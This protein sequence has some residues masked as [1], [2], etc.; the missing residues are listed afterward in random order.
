[1]AEEAE[2]RERD[3]RP[4]RHWAGA[5]LGLLRT[6]PSSVAVLGV[7]CLALVVSLASG[8]AG[9][10]VTASAD[11]PTA[12]PIKHVVV[13][14]D[15]NVSFDHYFAT[16]PNA[17]N[18]DGQ[19]FHAAPG[20]P[21]VNGLTGALLSANP[22]GVNP[23][24]LDPTNVNQVLTCSQNHSYTPEENAF[25]GGLMDKF[26][27]TNGTATTTGKD[28]EGVACNAAP[29]QSIV[30]DYYDGNTVTAMW[31]YA[32]HY[33]MSDN[34]F[35]TS[36]G[37]S[38]PGAINLVSGDTGGVDTAHEVRSFA[39]DVVGDGLGGQSLIGDA[40]PYWDDCSTGTSGTLALKGTN[41]GNLLNAAGLSWGWFEGG[42]TPT[43]PY[44]GTVDTPSS[45]NQL[46]PDNTPVTCT[47]TNNVGAALGGTGATGADPWGTNANYVEHWEPFQ[48]YA[49]TANP[50]HLAP[51]SLGAVGTDTASPGEFNTANHNYDVTTFNSLVSA[52]DNGSL[53]ASN[54][55]AVSY[56]KAPVYETGHP[57]TS[58]PIDEQDWLVNEVNAIESLPTWSSTAIFVTYDDSD[59]WYDHDYSGVTNPSTG[60][61]DTL[62][63]AGVCG[64]EPPAPL[65]GEQGRCGF[66]PRLPLLAI[67]PCA[68]QN[69]VDHELSDQASILNFIEYNWR[70]PSIPGSY[71]SVLAKTDQGEGIPFDLAGLFDF[72]QCDAPALMLNPA[73]GEVGLRNASD[74][75]ENLQGV[76]YSSA[77]A[78]TA[79]F[80]GSNLSDAFLEGAD[81][82]GATLQGANLGGANLSLANLSDTELSGAN[83]Q[84][85]NLTGANLTGASL[86]GA[87]LQGANLTDANLTDANPQGSN[88]QGANLTG[89]NLSGAVLTG[90]NLHDATLTDVTW[91]D[92]TCPDGT[93]SSSDGGTCTDNGAGT[94]AMPG[95]TSSTLVAPTVTTPTVTTPATTTPTSPAGTNLPGSDL[96]GENLQ[97]DNL[98]G[99]N[100]EG[101]NLAGAA[102]AGDNLQGANAQ[103]DNLSG[104][105]LT[106]DDLQ[107]D[108]LTNTSLK[109]TNLSGANLQGANLT[110]ADLTGAELTGANLA[111]V[112]WSNTTCPDATNSNADANSCL[113]H[114]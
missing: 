82:Q 19:P 91:S 21:S 35:E 73:T 17:T 70:L 56:L 110:G 111:G 90:A 94:P 80:Q 76:N 27:A 77:D 52:I 8:G 34:N 11:V 109:D 92:T 5:R 66:G 37:P 108:N 26:T 67:S 31:N 95:A 112:V 99:D 74:Q 114:I 96:Q 113:G 89:A 105:N 69:Y 14:F 61:A 9:A 4:T 71:D 30:M 72:S 2:C 63:G 10:S 104:D 65:A 23:V 22:N 85:D 33:A 1:M 47:S 45:Y 55:P 107:D 28:P 24:R 49:S 51:S 25:D 103:G 46:A 54:F 58:D 84:G 81:L 12:T 60:S 44:A 87:N 53:P 36:F 106:G 40:N 79:D 98:Q 32:Q 75:G 18:A 42:F 13:I 29:E 48:F 50:H 6:R 68:K 39:S 88:L 93:N 78:T 101:T 64:A 86:Q 59:G 20:T 15:E 41:I 100:L 43:T 7:V 38:S 3:L 16:Y 62:S 102:L 57:A 97:G 83:L